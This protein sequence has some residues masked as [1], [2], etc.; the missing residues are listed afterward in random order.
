[1]N[2]EN[3]T[4]EEEQA[5]VKAVEKQCM[6]AIVQYLNELVETM[7]ANNIV[8]LSASDLLSMAEVMNARVTSEY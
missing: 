1:M 2:N 4:N 5:V 7:K 3:L 6:L 8:A